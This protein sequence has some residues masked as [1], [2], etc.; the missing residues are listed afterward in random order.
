MASKSKKLDTWDALLYGGLFILLALF[1]YQLLQLW[2][3]TKGGIGSLLSNAGQALANTIGTA[4]GFLTGLVTSPFSAL[5]SLF[6]AI[7]FLFSL[8]FSFLGSIFGGGVGS[9]EDLTGLEG[10]TPSSGLVVGQGSSAL[11]I[12]PTPATN[13]SGFSAPQNPGDGGLSDD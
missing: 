7:P 11:G 9:I 8:I 4:E 2:N 6:N 12:L 10:G 3:S 5:S 1:I 13:F